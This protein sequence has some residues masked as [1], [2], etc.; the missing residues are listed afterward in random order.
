MARNWDEPFGLYGLLAEL[1]ET[2]PN[3]EWVEFT[4]RPG[5]ALLRRQPGDGRGRGLVDGDAG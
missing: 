5:G 4:L 1:V 2:G 3:R